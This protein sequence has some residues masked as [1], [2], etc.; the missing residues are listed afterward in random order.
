MF[1][2]LSRKQQNINQELTLLGQYGICNPASSIKHRS[3]DIHHPTSN[4]GHPAPNIFH[5]ASNT[6]H[7]TS[8]TR[9]PTSFS[10][11]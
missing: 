11:Y 5:P 8:N 7:P 10:N 1:R 9:H 2:E 6:G 4:T 3:P